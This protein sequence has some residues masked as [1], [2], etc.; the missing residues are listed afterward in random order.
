MTPYASLNHFFHTRRIT[1]SDYRDG[2]SPNNDTLYSIAWLD[3]G[4]EPVILSHPDMGERY[5]AF[6]IASMTSDNFA[7]VGKRMTGSNPGHFAICGPDWVGDLPAGVQKLADSPTAAVLIFGRTAIQG[8]EDEPAVNRLQDQ[9]KLTQLSLWDK[10]KAR[11]PERRDVPIPFDS[12]TDPLADWKTINQAMIDNPPLRQN[13][14]MLDLLETIG[15]GP[16]QDVSKMDFA[17]QK[18]ADR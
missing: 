2:G 8:P 9:Y 17:T 7:Y 16:G 15:I 10:P 1:T 4:K 3:I 12:R 11:V 5:F 14:F 13:A 18:S 6:E